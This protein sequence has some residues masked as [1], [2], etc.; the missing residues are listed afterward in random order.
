MK[1]TVIYSVTV[2]PDFQDRVQR[3]KQVMRKTS[4]G[5]VLVYLMDQFE[6]N[7]ADEIGDYERAFA[8][9]DKDMTME[10][11]VASPQEALF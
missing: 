6:K 2:P 3:A 11:E 10:K 9:K 8:V 5:S 1:K 4:N 7:Y